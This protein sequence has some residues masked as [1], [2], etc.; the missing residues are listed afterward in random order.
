MGAR[1][2]VDRKLLQLFKHEVGITHGEVMQL[3]E[4]VQRAAEKALLSIWLKRDDDTW[5]EGIG[6]VV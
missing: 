1:E 2:Y 5:L 6:G 4:E 3:R